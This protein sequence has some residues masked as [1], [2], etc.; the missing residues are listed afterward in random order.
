MTDSW[1]HYITVL[2]PLPQTR[3]FNPMRVDLDLDAEV[4]E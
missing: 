2:Y 1:M 3:D 4:A